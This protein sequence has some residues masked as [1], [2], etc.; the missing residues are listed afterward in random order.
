MGQLGP[1]GVFCDLRVNRV[2]G[3]TPIKTKSSNERMVKICQNWMQLVQERQ[4]HRSLSSHLRFLL[5]AQG[6]P[7]LDMGSVAVLIP[8]VHED[9][10]C[11][12]CL[13]VHMT[14]T[15]PHHQLNIS[16]DS[17][18]SVGKSATSSPIHLRKNRHCLCRDALKIRGHDCGARDGAQKNGPT[19][20]WP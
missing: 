17:K 10:G 6:N 1:T 4:R 7:C 9:R 5:G 16:A 20:S 3:E 18:T 14:G 12:T 13:A 19:L 11:A 15:F 2:K 8:T